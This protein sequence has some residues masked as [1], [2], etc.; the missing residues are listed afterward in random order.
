MAEASLD[1]LELI[2]AEAL[3]RQFEQSPVEKLLLSYLQSVSDHTSVG[4]VTVPETKGPPPRAGLRGPCW[5]GRATRGRL[6]GRSPGPGGPGGLAEESPPVWRLV[7][8]LPAD[9]ARC[10]VLPRAC[11]CFAL[12]RW[13]A[14]ELLEAEFVLLKSSQI[15]KIPE[16]NIFC[17]F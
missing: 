9:C 12:A 10:T 4:L 16:G 3:A 7:G 1:L 2:W 5:D 11:V 13:H 15:C 6:G 14:K 17:H 8:G